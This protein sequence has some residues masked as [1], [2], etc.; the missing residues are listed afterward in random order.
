V[1]TPPGSIASPDIE[2]LSRD[3]AEAVEQQSA[4]SQVLEAI[5]RSGFELAP[6]FETVVHHAVRLCKADSGMIWQL[7][8]DVYRLA[9]SL[10]E[11]P[12]YRRLL[13]RK[14]IARASGATTADEIGMVGLVGLQRRTVLITDARTDPRYE[15][16]EALEL[17]GQRSMLGVPMLAGDQ[18]IGIIVLNRRTVDPFDE[19]TIRLATTFAAQGSIAIQNVQLFREMERRGGEL[20][21]SVDELRVLGEISQAVSSSLDLDEVLTTIVTRAVQLSGAEGGSIFE[22]DE[23]TSLFGIRASFGTDE[24]LVE[25]IRHVRIHLRETFLGR[26]AVTG[27]PGQA[28]DLDQE[29]SDPHV[30]ELRRA[31]W[32]SMLVVPLL[33]ELEIIGA[34]VVRR[35]ATGAFPE[36]IADLLE[37]LASQSAVAIHNARVYREL[38]EKTRQLEVASEHKSEFLASMSHELRTPLNAVIGFS[39]VLLEKMFGDIN[40]R[41]E[42]YLH[43]IRNSGRHLLELINEIL[44]LS[45]VEAGRME[46]E[47]GSVSVADVVEHGLAM[48]RERA[49]RHEISIQLDL[50]SPD[51]RIWADEL[52][53]KQVVLNLLS[54]AV[55]FTGDGGSVVI[56]SRTTGDEAHVTVRDTGAGIPEAD[57][58]RIFDAFQRGA[59]SAR[60]SAE[61]TGLGLTLSKRIVELHGGR[62]WMTSRVGV[63]STFGFAIPIRHTAESAVGAVIS[64][65]A[66]AGPPSDPSTAMILVVE[67][68]RRSA[69]LLTLHLERAGLTVTVARDGV[70]GLE[71]ARRLRPH[72]IVLD[73]RL[74]RLD[75]W[76]LLALLKADR[77]TSDLPVLVVSMIDERG[78]GFALGAADYLLKPV[79][80]DQIR[81]ALA[82]CVPT[83]AESRTVV[84]IDDD[85]IELD[86]IEA[87]LGPKGYS[88]LRAA[89]GDEGVELVRRTRPAVVLLDLLMPEV[90]GFDVVERL[91]ADPATT[92]VP[93]VVLTSKDI[94]PDDRK[95]L[96]G[97]ISCIA[98]KGAGRAGL[99]ELVGRLVDVSYSRSKDVP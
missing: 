52:K 25:K 51:E 3:L 68:D 97:Q 27:E 98:E 74:P 29:P 30:D 35:R 23:G 1:A 26:A 42:E 84:V 78:K 40:P 91:R 5:G 83:I 77:T 36:Q 85:P 79:S 73:I 87:T 58:E 17:E 69:D 38:E 59:R 88:I 28:P 44:D 95:R 6:V 14:T 93:I 99:V 49:S 9:C 57:H 21:R 8:G 64:T 10:G 56:T 4:A 41:Q 43:D 76:D 13:E 81:D 11:S 65:D 37:T 19:R 75:G 18:A 80:G 50:E 46:L 63:G 22:F 90:D 67:D 86:L 96:A 70:E 12:E 7:D 34:L 32:R 39:D 61:G 89:G 24:E 62:M 55:K 53:L 82:R 94:A 45:K 92:H 71:L 60:E 20:A 48:M 2:H 66:T 47:L 15:W 72:A 54:N 33:R 31:G 16:P